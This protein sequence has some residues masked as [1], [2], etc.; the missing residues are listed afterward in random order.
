MDPYERLAEAVIERA[1]ADYRREKHALKQKPWSGPAKKK[2]KELEEFFH[3]P[4]FEVFSRLDG[5]YI[6][7]RLKKEA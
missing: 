4:W 3:S 1:A 2:V 5:E 6:L 7:E